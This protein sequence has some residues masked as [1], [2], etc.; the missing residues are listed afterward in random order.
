MERQAYTKL[1]E[2]KQK[3]DRK[4]LILNGARQIGK[5]WL[6]QDFGAAEYKKTA[7]IN[8][9]KNKAIRD[10]FAQDYDMNRV[11]R[12]I[13]A[14]TEVD[15]ESGNTLIILDEIQSLPEGMSALKY[16]C[17]DAPQYHVAVAGSMLG[18]ALHEKSGFPVGKVDMIRMYPMNFE[19]FVLA[20]GKTS[21]LNILQQRDYASMK[22]LG[23][24]FTDLLRQYYFT[25]GMPAVVAAYV[26]EKGLNAVRAL[27]NQILYDYSNDFSKHAPAKEVPRINMVWQSI[28]SQLAKDNKKFIYGAMK[29][30]ARANEFEMAIQWLIDMGLVYKINRTT[31]PTVPLKFYEDFSAFK[32]FMLDCGLLGALSETPPG[33]IL[34]NNNIFEEYKGAFTEL[35]VLQQ[36]KALGCLPV[37]YFSADD[38]RIEIDFVI[39]A[40]ERVIPVEVKAEENLRA[41]SLKQY[42]EKHPELKGLRFSMSPYR[43]QDWMENVPLYAVLSDLRSICP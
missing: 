29:K 41:K 2:W 42:V 25:G 7:Y 40:G 26:E 16:F 39:Q 10:L 32:L 23:P 6:L 8:C 38:T 12:V 18:V 3:E 28:P 22:V 4:P 9:D 21:L 43:D 27:Q 33:L 35:Y 24:Q 20:L 19:E 30:G 34:S 31:K 15:I 1:L 13:S 11:I 17:E 14:L 36:M 37:Y 5:T